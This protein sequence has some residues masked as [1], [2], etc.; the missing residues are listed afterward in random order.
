MNPYD[1]IV[2]RYYELLNSKDPLIMSEEAEFRGICTTL[3]GIL[4]EQN[5]DVL[6]RLKNR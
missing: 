1:A 5:K 2:S 6:V 3:L 4:L